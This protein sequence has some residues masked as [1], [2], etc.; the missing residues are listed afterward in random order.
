ME[1]FE[2]SV[3]SQLNM[4]KL[5][6]DVEKVN[7][8]TMQWMLTSSYYAIIWNEHLIDCVVNITEILYD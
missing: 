3:E 5:I 4:F 2:K 8:D 7:F 6:S 1:H